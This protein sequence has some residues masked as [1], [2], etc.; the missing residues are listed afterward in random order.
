MNFLSPAYV[1]FFMGSKA[2][3]QFMLQQYTAVEL[4]CCETPAGLHHQSSQPGA[5]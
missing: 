1:L 5:V 4:L 2:E 3:N